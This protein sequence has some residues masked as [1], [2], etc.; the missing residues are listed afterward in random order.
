MARNIDKYVMTWHKAMDELIKD[1][2]GYSNEELDYLD[3]CYFNY[4]DGYFG[5][6]PNQKR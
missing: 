3:T 5:K 1:S 4:M 2:S 6:I